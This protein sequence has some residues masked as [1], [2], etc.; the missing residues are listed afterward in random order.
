[1]E[2]IRS[3]TP[4]RPPKDRVRRMRQAE[5]AWLRYLRS[6]VCRAAVGTCRLNAEA[7]A[8]E[9]T[10]FSLDAGAHT[11]VIPTK[12]VGTRRHQAAIRQ[13][14][15]EMQRVRWQLV[16]LGVAPDGRIA[17]RWSGMEI[18]EVQSKHRWLTP[19]LETGE[20]VCYVLCITRNPDAPVDL[21]GV[22]V[23][24]VGVEQAIQALPSL[25]TQA[26]A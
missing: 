6:D 23:V 21:A 8:Y 22:N 26:A 5:R 2:M 13:L 25:I 15:L 20:V 14:E 1:M 16:S 9:A 17:A 12:L 7:K 24:F 18:G 11:W 10:T 19:L 4:D 3:R